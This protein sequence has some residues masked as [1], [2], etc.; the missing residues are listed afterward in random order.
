MNNKQEILFPGF[1]PWRFHNWW[2]NI[3]T[4][5]WGVKC[6]F[7]RGL[8]G[9]SNYDTISID[10]YFID[11]IPPMLKH[12]KKY[13]H[14]Y[15]GDITLEE[16]D[17]ILNKIIVGF[18]SGRKIIDMGF[19]DEN[20]PNKINK[21]KYDKLMFEFDTGFELFHKYFFGLWD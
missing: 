15:P 2:Y 20:S 14:G 17:E 8:Y 6:F 12:L 10:G 13:Q 3:T 4:I 1:L 18:E 11:I 16:W 19:Y 7:H 9:W 21:E 5:Y